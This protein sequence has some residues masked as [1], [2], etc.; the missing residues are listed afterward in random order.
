M[1][2]MILMAADIKDHCIPCPELVRTGLAVNLSR[3][4]LVVI[5]VIITISGLNGEE[6]IL[7]NFAGDRTAIISEIESIEATY[8]GKTLAI[9]YGDEGPYSH[10]RDLIPLPVFQGNPYLIDIVALG[11]MISAGLP[12]PAATIGKLDEGAVAV[13]VIPSGSPPFALHG[14]TL[15]PFRQV[16]FSQ[17]P[18]GGENGTLRYL[19]L[20][21]YRSL[22]AGF[23]FHT[24]KRKTSKKAF[25][26]GRL[27]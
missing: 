6:R 24:E 5:A 7:K 18:A 15:E 13:W 26:R 2:I 21:Q 22:I 14:Q 23:V 27:V 9:G 4:I 25:C 20:R 1:Y 17:L 16:L 19:G 8:A 11:D 12:L 3:A 10:Y